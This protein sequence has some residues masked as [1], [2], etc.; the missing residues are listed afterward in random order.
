MTNAQIIME[1]QEQLLADG[2]LKYTGRTITFETVDGE[3]VEIQEIQPIH[4]YNGWK[5]RGYQ[6]K[7]GSKAVA[8]FP[9][10]KMSTKKKKEKDEESGEEKE[11]TNGRMFM[12]LSSFFTDE[13][14]EKIKEAK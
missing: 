7:K 9:I 3:E 8:Q 5:A 12:K 11:V 6:V 14:V 13:Q 10:W 2:V 4:T 1:M